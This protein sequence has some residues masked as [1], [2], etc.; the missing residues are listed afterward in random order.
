MMTRCF[1]LI[2][3]FDKYYFLI[4]VLKIGGSELD[5]LSLLREEQRGAVFA[6]EAV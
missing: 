6:V 5:D 2:S 3:I 4:S 1:R